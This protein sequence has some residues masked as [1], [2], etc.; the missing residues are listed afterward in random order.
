MKYHIHIIGIDLEAPAHL[1]NFVA[2]I[3]QVQKFAHTAG[4]S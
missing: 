1:A 2:L 4:E 3:R